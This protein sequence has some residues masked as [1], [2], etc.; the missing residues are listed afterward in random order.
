MTDMNPSF[1][2]FLASFGSS[3]NVNG[4]IKEADQDGDG[5]IM[6]CEFYDFVKAKWNGEETLSDDIIC[7]FWRNVM[8]TNKSVDKIK[9]TTLRNLNALDKEEEKN[10][11]IKLQAYVTFNEYIN[12]LFDPTNAIKWPE[13]IKSWKDDMKDNLQG[14][15]DKYLL[16]AGQNYDETTLK[17]LIKD[18]FNENLIDSLSDYVRIEVSE[19][20]NRQ[21]NYSLRDYPNY[22]IQK[23]NDLINLVNVAIA[24]F[25][26]NIGNNDEAGSFDNLNQLGKNLRTRVDQIVKEYIENS[27]NLE[28]VTNQGEETYTLQKEVL[29][30]KAINLIVAEKDNILAN[31]FE[32]NNASS[33]LIDRIW[34]TY[35][36]NLPS[37][38]EPY[39]N[40]ITSSQMDYQ[41]EVD[42]NLTAS[43]IANEV[44]KLA[45]AEF[46]N[47]YVSEYEYAEEAAN[48]V[49]DNFLAPKESNTD[50]LNELKEDLT[51]T[52]IK[53]VNR[54]YDKM[55]IAQ[56]NGEFD[57]KSNV[58]NTL[59]LGYLDGS[60]LTNIKKNL[61]DNQL[62]YGKINLN[63]NTP[64]Y[65]DEL[66]SYQEACIKKIETLFLYPEPK[67]GYKLGDKA[68]NY[69]NYQE[70]ISSYTDAIQLYIDMN[71]LISSI[72]PINYLNNQTQIKIDSIDIDD[73]KNTSYLD[74][75]V[76]GLEG[77]V[78]TKKNMADYSFAELYNSEAV[79]MLDSGT[80]KFD[81]ISNST[82]SK[83]KFMLAEVMLVLSNAGF[84]LPNYFV[85]DLF[86]RL[87]RG[88]FESDCNIQEVTSVDITS[89]GIY[90]A[91]EIKTKDC[92]EILV[93]NDTTNRPAD[94]LNSLGIIKP[95]ESELNSLGI[96]KAL[97]S[98]AYVMMISF[99]D[100]VDKILKSF[101]YM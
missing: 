8:D 67:D 62:N 63:T 17:N 20:F 38:I 11:E 72:N 86:H 13:H 3:D 39:I 44:I 41:M 31:V 85:E 19:F 4:W 60:A 88:M 15:L 48:Y 37:T 83:I 80:N 36:E 93:V 22:N 69:D 61:T 16:E 89:L 2:R 94:L 45:P 23:D 24:D 7:K 81:T 101:G 35:I 10:M 5:K 96:I 68:I 12:E 58:F 91:N 53:A 30:K 46:A 28:K 84:E 43:T 32:L 82:E 55:I 73:W 74:F 26:K 66:T 25:K 21:I 100:L 92:E 90:A 76:Y 59:Y 27:V 29:E 18:A 56:A 9:G 70:L 34:N 40:K 75:Q 98:D 33:T 47:I 78:D 97:E 71:A 99:K 95:L 65:V 42:V 52:G 79:I 54:Y 51:E 64:L 87:V 14:V 49:V 1:F 77:G 50:L 6:R 57:V